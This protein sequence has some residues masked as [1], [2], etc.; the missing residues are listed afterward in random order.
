MVVT[1][2]TYTKE[3]TKKYT[4]EYCETAFLIHK[5]TTFII[6]ICVF[7]C[8]FLMLMSYIFSSLSKLKYLTRYENF[9]SSHVSHKSNLA[10]LSPIQVRWF[11]VRVKYLI[12]QSRNS[13]V[14]RV[15]VVRLE[16]PSVPMA[17][18]I[19]EIFLGNTKLEGKLI[20]EFQNVYV[21]SLKTCITNCEAVNIFTVN[22][23][24]GVGDTF[25]IC[26]IRVQ[27]FL[28]SYPY[29]WVEISFLV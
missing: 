23:G 24:S 12:P 13:S 6:I 29:I 26:Y 20:W 21:F 11:Q 3:Y 8:S 18:F 22:Y 28:G 4:K 14:T 19:R 7:L 9:I 25:L 10:S 15:Q 5:S 27:V 2:Y 16:S 1:K 17:G